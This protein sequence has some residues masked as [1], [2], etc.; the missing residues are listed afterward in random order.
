MTKKTHEIIVE[1]LSSNKHYD[2]NRGLTPLSE[3][4][5]KYPLSSSS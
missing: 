4:S 1:D 2:T 5:D 3:N